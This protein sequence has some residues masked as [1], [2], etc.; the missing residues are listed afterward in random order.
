MLTLLL[1]DFVQVGRAEALA[2]ADAPTGTPAVPVGL[3]TL[4]PILVEFS[5]LFLDS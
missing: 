1:P 2:T 5:H 4:Y 3:T